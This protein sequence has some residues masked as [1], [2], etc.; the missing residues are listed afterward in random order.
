MF[1]I[2]HNLLFI[3][4][5]FFF[6][7]CAF[8]LNAGILRYNTM[9]GKLVQIPNYDTQ[10]YSLCRLQLVVDTQLNVP[11]NQKSPKLLSQRI[12]K[13]YCK[14]L[15]TSVINSPMSPPSLGQHTRKNSRNDSLDLK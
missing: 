14:T 11:T 3:F 1:E 9:V 10:N 7:I 12:R 6:Y 8:V 5:I 15:R 4:I 13:R 2:G